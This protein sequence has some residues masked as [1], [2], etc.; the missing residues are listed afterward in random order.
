MFLKNS[1]KL[2][3][4]FFLVTSNKNNKLRDSY[5][6]GNWFRRQSGDNEAHDGIKT[7]STYS[8]NNR[9]NFHIHAIIILHRVIFLHN[10]RFNY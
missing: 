9:N 4:I 3:I 8:C 1:R 5:K 2:Y 10:F 7:L 6:D